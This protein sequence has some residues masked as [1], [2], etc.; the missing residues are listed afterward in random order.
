MLIYTVH[1]VYSPPAVRIL[2][3]GLS[4]PQLACL[5]VRPAYFSTVKTLST[6]HRLTPVWCLGQYS[7]G[8][9]D[10][11]Q[12]SLMCSTYIR[13]HQLSPATAMTA[14]AGAIA[15]AEVLA[16]NKHITHMDLRDNDIRVAGLMGLQ[17]AHRMNH[18]LLSLDTPKFYKVEQVSPYTHVSG[19]GPSNYCK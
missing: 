14:T 18:T 4:S 12:V 7:I 9:I 6:P 1:K 8:A 16:E 15:L 13:V 19:D 2:V 5:N 10:E 17:L 3:A 11:W